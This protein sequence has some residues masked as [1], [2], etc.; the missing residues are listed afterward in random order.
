MNTMKK[1]VEM[2]KQAKA[3][4]TTPKIAR[5][6]TRALK[7]SG[8]IGEKAASKPAPSVNPR[9]YEVRV[10]E[11]VSVVEA[12]IDVGLGNALFIRGQGDG[13]SWEQG[14]PLVCMNAST[15]VWHS[16]QARDKVVFKLLVNDQVCAKGADMVLEAGRKLEVVPAF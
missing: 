5:R 8:R 1:T 3:V 15:W 14:Q 4:G 2:N 9:G 7:T 11:T 10:P 13:L 12:R 16:G 6:T